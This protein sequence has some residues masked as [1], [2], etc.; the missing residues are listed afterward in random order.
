MLD[1]YYK[2]LDSPEWKQK[3]LSILKRDD[4]KCKICGKEESLDTHLNVHHRYYLF[5]K[6]AWEYDDNAL[7]TPMPGDRSVASA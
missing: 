1:S 6:R 5:T 2:Q 7:V 3:R 4:F